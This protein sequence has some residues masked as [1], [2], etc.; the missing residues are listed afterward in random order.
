MYFFRTQDGI[1]VAY[2]K[3]LKREERDCEYVGLA[4]L[5]AGFIEGFKKRVDNCVSRELYDL[6][7]ENVLY[8]YSGEYPVHVQDVD[9]RFWGEIDYVSDYNRILE[10]FGLPD[11]KSENSVPLK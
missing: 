2:G 3:E 4:R 8:I 5:K 9:G 1:I 6:W 7:W 10:H 11:F